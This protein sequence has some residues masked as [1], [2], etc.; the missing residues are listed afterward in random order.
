M[1]ELFTTEILSANKP[2]T[3]KPWDGLRIIKT[4]VKQPYFPITPTWT[5][6]GGTYHLEQVAKLSY[7]DTQPASS[8]RWCGYRVLDVADLVRQIKGASGAWNVRLQVTPADGE[9]KIYMLKRRRDGSIVNDTIVDAASNP[10]IAWDPS[11]DAD[12]DVW[13]GFS[14]FKM[15]PPPD[16]TGQRPS[17]AQPNIYFTIDIALIK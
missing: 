10:V 5:L 12:A 2:E 17:I 6:N 9:H 16:K 1:R 3:Y 4:A 7:P 13:V 14:S 15:L 8:Y 11:A